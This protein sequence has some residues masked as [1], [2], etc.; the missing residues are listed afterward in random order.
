VDGFEWWY[1]AW[2]YCRC[3]INFKEGCR[4]W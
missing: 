4:V 3:T 2:M 1:M